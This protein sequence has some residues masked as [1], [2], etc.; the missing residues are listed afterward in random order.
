M[1]NLN[2]KLVSIECTDGLRMK[3]YL[4]LSK[5]NFATIIHIHG[6]FGNFYENEFIPIMAERY[7]DS[8][9]N[10]LS[11]NNRGHDGIAE[12]DKTQLHKSQKLLPLL[13]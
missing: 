10:F 12:M 5:E 3:G 2:G 6:N 4:A 9:L 11:I 13:S 1:N 8:G 7:T